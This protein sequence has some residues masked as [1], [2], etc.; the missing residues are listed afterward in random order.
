MRLFSSQPLLT[1]FMKI[2][3]RL[4]RSHPSLLL[5][6]TQSLP[7]RQRLPKNFPRLELDDAGRNSTTPFSFADLDLLACQR[8]FPPIGRAS[9][10]PLPPSTS[11]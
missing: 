3:I 11:S 8:S 2:L 1:H 9:E 6:L 10:W 5:Q 7:W 4:L